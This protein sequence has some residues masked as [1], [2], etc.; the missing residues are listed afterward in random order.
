MSTFSLKITHFLFATIL[1]RQKSNQFTNH[2][3]FLFQI[4]EILV[5]CVIGTNFCQLEDWIAMK[6][7]TISII[8]TFFLRVF[9]NV[10]VAGSLRG[11]IYISSRHE[12]E[13]FGQCSPRHFR[14]TISA[15]I[16][17]L[18]SNLQLSNSV[19]IPHR[20]C[21][22]FCGVLWWSLP[23]WSWKLPQANGTRY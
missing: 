14:W 22:Q 17:E 23:L 18:H 15:F 1:K 10:D 11:V 8:C 16:R 2:I 20:I 5:P 9:L 4:L 21:P 6:S 13:A 7:C 19:Q 3:F 12:E